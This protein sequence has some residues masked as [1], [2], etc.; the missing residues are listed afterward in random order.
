MAVVLA[1][2]RQKTVAVVNYSVDSGFASSGTVIRPNSIITVAGN[3][4]PGFRGDNGPATVA[5]LESPASVAVDAAGDIFIAESGADH[6]QSVSATRRYR[7][8]L[9][10][11]TEEDAAIRTT[12]GTHAF[13]G[14]RGRPEESGPNVL[15]SAR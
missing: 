1:Q 14:N 6:W 15:P 9:D 13:L 11:R 5:S 7:I 10:D 4:R 2:Q 8:V 12:A 3:G